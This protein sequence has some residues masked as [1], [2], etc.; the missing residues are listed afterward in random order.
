MKAAGVHAF[1]YTEGRGT[2]RPVRLLH[3]L[4]QR[5]SAARANF[6]TA[7]MDQNLPDWVR[8]DAFKGA[9]GISD[10]TAQEEYYGRLFFV[11]DP[12]TPY[13]QDKLTAVR[14]KPTGSSV[15]HTAVP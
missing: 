6:W 5:A 2:Y 12:A 9:C 4:A 10:T 13:W 11:M 1:P 14:R 3:A 15:V 7:V 8:D